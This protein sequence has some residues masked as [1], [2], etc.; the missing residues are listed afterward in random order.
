MKKS[1][2][3]A[4]M[5][6]IAFVGAAGFTACS[7][8]DEIVDN[9]NYNPETNTVK[10]QFAISIPSNAA[11]NTRMSEEIVQGQAEPTFRGIQNVVLIPF[12]T[13][14]TSSS[15]RLGDNI[16]LPETT[17]ETLGSNNSKVYSNVALKVGT[18]AFLFYGEAKANY[19]NAN[20][21]T[22]DEKFTNGQISLPTLTGNPGSFTFSLQ[23]IHASTTADAKATGLCTYI[24]A[25]AAVDASGDY[26]LG[27]YIN[28]F[29]TLKGGSSATILDAVQ[30][31]RN[32]VV[33]YVT[34][35][36]TITSL[37]NSIISAIDNTTY[38]T[39]S[40]GTLTLIDNY[41][42]YPA[43]INLPD[44]AASI[45]WDG[46]TASPALTS[47][48]GGNTASLTSYVYPPS[49]Y[50]RANSL[51]KVST[52][53]Q[54]SNYS[55]KTSWSAITTD[56]YSAGAVDGSTRSVALVDQVQYAVGRMDLTVKT[57]A[58]L[59][60]RDGQEVTPDAAGFPVSAVLIG[61]QKNVDFE[62]KPTGT[63][64]YTIYDKKLD[65][66]KAKTD[67]TGGKNHTLVFETDNDNVQIA[68]ELTNNTNKEFKGRNGVIPINGKFYL[69]GTLTI[70]NGT[71]P[72][73]GGIT[74][75]FLQDYITKVNLT[76]QSNEYNADTNPNKDQGL[77]DAY[78]VLP[79]LQTPQLELGL[80]VNLTWESGLTFNVNI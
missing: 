5:S 74:K 49:L 56:L 53:E 51:V 12:S 45:T 63:D 34:T 57:A 27:N 58:T 20:S 9:P 73:G 28:D 76:I 6:A 4:L 61:S 31:L 29:K 68:I 69:V 14:A 70:A 3:Y 60:D 35:D 67:D 8:S 19:A 2:V 15:T 40:S 50:Y 54:S 75:V 38:V 55:N 48:A 77:G 39:E 71:Q 17:I 44:G 78:N 47:N 37:K 21:I 42:G 65:G 64:Y 11:G 72:D 33:A 10:T 26:T 30:R 22:V 62:F 79:D 59:Y 18:G 25:I 52:S 13:T 66:I 41:A 43:N 16:E 23:Q 36:E 24:S 32:K 1:Y 46:N 7:S 80:S